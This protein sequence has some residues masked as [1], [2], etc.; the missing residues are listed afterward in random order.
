MDETLAPGACAPCDCTPSDHSSPYPVPRAPSPGHDAL[1]AS[2]RAAGCVFA[3]EEATLILDAAGRDAPPERR[4]ELVATLLARRTAGEP[5]EH[6]VGWAD[7]CGLRIAVAPGVFVPR[8]RSEFL[9]EQALRLGR[10]AAVVVE[11]CCGAAPLATVAA[12][13]L[14]HARVHAAD[15]D[16]VQAACARRNLAPFTGRASVHEGDLFAALPPR[17]RGRVDLLVANAPYV[18]TADIA[19]MPVEAREHEPR[20][21]LDGGVDGLA[22]HRRIAAGAPQWLARGGHVLIET[23]RYQHRGTGDALAAAGL[24][25]WTVA[26]A[27][28]EAVVAV[29]RLR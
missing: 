29:G 11:L 3:E 24:E 6:V 22:L 5:L 19:M 27:E 10:G 2:L 20:H 17:L 16:P 26:C 8:R 18:P 4:E 25:A 28:R 15:I 13:R 7:F 21:S 12:G 1:V 14:P 9:A 23:S